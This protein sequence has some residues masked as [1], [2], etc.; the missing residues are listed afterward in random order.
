MSNRN[1]EDL[2]LTF[3]Q[4][5]GKAPLPEPMELEVLS[6]NFRIR[7]WRLIAD[8]IQDAAWTYDIYESD[9]KNLSRVLADFKCEVFE[10]WDDPA[11][12]RPS[13]DS[14]FVMN[15]CS[16]AEYHEV[17]T[18]IE[19]MF[20]HDK[21]PNGLRHKL[22]DVF[23]QPPLVAYHVLAIDG[24]LT[25]VPRACLESG[26]ATRKALEI[27]EN[28]GPKG[29]KVH[30]QNAANNI[31]AAEYA[32]AIRESIHAVEAVARTI[33][34]TAKTLSGALKTLRNKGFLGHP[35][36]GQAFEKLY[37]YTSDKKGIRHSMTDEGAA[38]VGLDEAMFM[39]S[40]CAAG[41]AYL[42]RKHAED[43]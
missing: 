42:S 14:Q 36:I 43:G 5:V 1:D 19:F 33:E 27:V 3:S 9:G 2:K 16:N 15:Y 6:E 34:P 30:F 32:D 41:A 25:V 18:L 29:A 38:D 22:I 12:H 21:C 35:A 20:R 11:N 4:R 8:S 39:F 24:S 37:A 28:T 7:V 17:L 13:R 31:N 10:E 23:H 26:D 40:A